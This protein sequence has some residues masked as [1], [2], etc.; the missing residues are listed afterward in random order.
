MVTPVETPAGEPIS[1]EHPEP[2]EDADI[3]YGPL[4]EIAE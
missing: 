2:F 3:D 4:T 1:R